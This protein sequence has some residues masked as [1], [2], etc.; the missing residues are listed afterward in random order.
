MKRRR[1][2]QQQLGRKISLINVCFFFALKIYSSF[3][4]L[5][6]YIYIYFIFIIEIIIKK[7]K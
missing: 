3:Q 2:K 6:I 7:K 1:K 4:E 5:Y